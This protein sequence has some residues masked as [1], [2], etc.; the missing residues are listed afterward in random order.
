MFR[1]H[2]YSPLI[3]Q[4]IGYILFSIAFALFFDLDVY[5]DELEDTS[6]P[7]IFAANHTSELDPPMF[8]LVLPFLSKH[9]PLYFVSAPKENYGRTSFGWRSY[10]YGGQLFNLLGA[11]PIASG[12]KNYAYALQQHIMLLRKGQ[13]ICIFPEGRRTLD[14]SLSKAH[15]G[16][17]YLSYVTGASV[18]PISINTFFNFSWKNIWE[19]MLRGRRRVVVRVGRP[20]SAHELVSEANPKVEDFQ[21]GAQMVVDTIGRM[22]QLPDEETEENSSVESSESIEKIENIIFGEGA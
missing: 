9:F 2:Y 10:I 4:K 3:L 1:Y 5:G 14:G 22:I 20:L 13:S 15:G 7:L 12:H 8:A 21:R 6:K 18:V 19:N 17:A 11:Y 16:V